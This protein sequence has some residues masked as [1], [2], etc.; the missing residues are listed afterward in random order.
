MPFQKGNNANPNGRPKIDK[1]YKH[2]KHFSLNEFLKEWS[3]CKYMSLREAKEILKHA[4]EYEV[5]FICMLRCFVK[6]AQTGDY[7]NYDK[8]LDRI[9]GKAPETVKY[10]DEDGKKLLGDLLL[11]LKAE[12]VI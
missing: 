11:K 8:M 4:D 2:I 9:L 6:I 5:G 1:D 3:Q 7:K 12:G 10:V